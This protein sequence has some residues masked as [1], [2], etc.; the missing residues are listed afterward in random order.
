MIEEKN[1][2]HEDILALLVYLCEL[3][4]DDVKTRSHSFLCLSFIDSQDIR[5]SKYGEFLNGYA[6]SVTNPPEYHNNHCLI[7]NVTSFDTL[8][9]LDD[10]QPKKKDVLHDNQRLFCNDN[11]TFGDRPVSC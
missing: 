3:A 8:N 7:D 10:T 9:S 2:I 6:P 1:N 11:N 5:R 4:I